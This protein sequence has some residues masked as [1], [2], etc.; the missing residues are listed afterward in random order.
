MALGLGLA[1]GHL[2]DAGRGNRRR[3]GRASPGSLADAWGSAL[4]APSFALAQSP[5]NPHDTAP[6]CSRVEKGTKNRFIWEVTH[7]SNSSGFA[8][9]ALLSA[10]MPDV[11]LD[12][13]CSI[14]CKHNAQLFNCVLQNAYPSEAK[15]QRSRRRIAPCGNLCCSSLP[16]PRATPD[17]AEQQ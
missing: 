6:V 11:L 16:T 3:A 10:G 17:D 2:V 1:S 7:S 15:L 4:P 13:C 8:A 12:S 9:L 14:G 5:S